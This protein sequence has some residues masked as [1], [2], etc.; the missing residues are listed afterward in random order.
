MCLSGTSD[1]SLLGGTDAFLLQFPHLKIT[2]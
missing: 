2:D 1:M